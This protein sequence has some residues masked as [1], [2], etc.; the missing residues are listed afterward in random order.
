METKMSNPTFLVKVWCEN[1]GHDVEVKVVSWDQH[2]AF[3]DA[4]YEYKGHC[5]NRNNPC[6]AYGHTMKVIHNGGHN[7]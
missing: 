6:N 7:D 2:D 3:H 4:E 5:G 1:N